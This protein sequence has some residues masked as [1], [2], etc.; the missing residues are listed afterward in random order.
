MSCWSNCIR[1]VLMLTFA[2]QTEPALAASLADE[3]T[4]MELLRAPAG[5]PLIDA[6]GAKERAQ[7]PLAGVRTYEEAMPL[8]SGPVLLIADSDAAALA[9]A[10][11]IEARHRGVQVYAVAGGA[12]VLQRLREQVTQSKP[13]G[14]TIPYEFVIPSDTCQTGPALQKFEGQ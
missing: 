14:A 12:A 5:I 1:A 3:L 4:V 8:A 13:S 9:L 7:A 11:K 10:G 2:L 6:R